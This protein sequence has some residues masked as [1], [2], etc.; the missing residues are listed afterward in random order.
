MITVTRPFVPFLSFM[1]KNNIH[2]HGIGWALLGHQCPNND[3]KLTIAN[4]QLAANKI[5]SYS[6]VVAANSAIESGS[7]KISRRTAPRKRF[8]CAHFMVGCAWDTF[9][10]AGSLCT[11]L[12]H[13]RTVR[14]PSCGSDEANSKNTKE[15]H[16]EKAYLTYRRQN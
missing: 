6:N 13:L 1:P 10:C 12:P 9:G 14:H 7:S 16:S 4:K 8:F 11:G 3:Q 2:A 15:F 5:I